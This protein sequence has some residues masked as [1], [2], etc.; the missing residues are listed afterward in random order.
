[1][2][3]Y[4]YIYYICILYI[5]IIYINLF[6]TDKRQIAKVSQKNNG[7]NTYKIMKTICPPSYR[8]NGFVATH[9]LGHMM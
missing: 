4:I 8:H 7:H 2:Y 1:M 3:I 6:T 5:Y 9:A